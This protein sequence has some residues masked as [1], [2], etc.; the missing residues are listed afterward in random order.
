MVVCCYST[1]SHSGLWPPLA[2]LASGTCVKEQ[3]PHAGLWPIETPLCS[4]YPKFQSTPSQVM[5]RWQVITS[6]VMNIG[7]IPHPLQIVLWNSKAV[8]SHIL[9]RHAARRTCWQEVER[10]Q[11]GKETYLRSR[12]IWT[13]CSIDGGSTSTIFGLLPLHEKLGLERIRIR[14]VPSKSSLYTIKNGCP[15]KIK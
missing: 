2:Q 7:H 4:M 6:C 13:P 9:W 12:T 14:V 3:Q 8:P 11:E 10:N 15:E 1:C 5:E